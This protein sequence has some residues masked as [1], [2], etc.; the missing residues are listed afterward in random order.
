[1]AH[2]LILMRHAKADSHQFVDDFDRVLTPR[3]ISEAAL[4]GQEI[5]DRGIQYVLCSSSARTRQTLEALAL[6]EIEGHQVPVDFS[7]SLYLGSPRTISQLIAQVP[8]HIES[9]LVIGHAPGIPSLAYDLTMLH[10]ATSGDQLS[11]FPTCSFA[12]FEMT[13][14]WSALATDEEDT[15]L[16]RI[17]RPADSR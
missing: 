1:M 12:E 15:Q 10:S 7:D 16:T 4:T 17:R 5:A 11:W 14:S 2:T 6:H 3:G 13:T 9:L 8:E